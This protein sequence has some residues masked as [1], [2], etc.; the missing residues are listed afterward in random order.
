MKS[1][2]IG[3][4]GFWDESLEVDGGGMKNVFNIASCFGALPLKFYDW[5]HILEIKRMSE[6]KY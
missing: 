4:L 1:V 2:D 5:V 3:L 6:S